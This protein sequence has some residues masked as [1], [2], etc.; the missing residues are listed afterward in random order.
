MGVV[1]IRCAWKSPSMALSPTGRMRCAIDVKTRVT[2][3]P[4]LSIT[5][6]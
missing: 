1:I 3:V 4:I 5:N 6:T 2:V